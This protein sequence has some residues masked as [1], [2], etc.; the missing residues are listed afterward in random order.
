MDALS[1]LGEDS[2]LVAEVL[3]ERDQLREKLGALQEEQVTV[4]VE[5]MVMMVK[6]M[7]VVM[8]MTS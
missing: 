8:V 1:K 3:E 6:V 2:P 4:V 7:L 5:V